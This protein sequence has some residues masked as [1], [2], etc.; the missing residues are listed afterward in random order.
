MCPLTN[1][2]VVSQL[3]AGTA[4]LATKCYKI[5]TTQFKYHAI[6]T[7]KS[8]YLCYKRCWKC[9]PPIQAHTLCTN[10]NRLKLCHEEDTSEWQSGT[11]C[12]WRKHVCAYETTLHQKKCQM[13]IN[14]T[15]MNW[16]QNVLAEINPASWLWWAQS[17]NCSH[18]VW[19]ELKQPCHF[20]CSWFRD[21][22]H[23][24]FQC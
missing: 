3:P 15:V 11:D 14:F 7:I 2:T 10:I 23:L 16:L 19:P 12:F 21:A 13:K 17:T 6:N 5:F 9:C 8:T 1:A 20:G 24:A 22:G 4:W 18:L